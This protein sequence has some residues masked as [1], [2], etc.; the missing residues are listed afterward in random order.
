VRELPWGWEA[1]KIADVADVNPQ[2]DADLSSGVPVS[3]IPMASVEAETGIVDL[4]Q[5]KLFGE[6]RS[7]SYRHFREGDVL[8]AKITPCMENGK[9]AVA[10]GLTNGRGF[11][12][13]EF[14]VLRPCSGFNPDYLLY[15]LLQKT[16]RR[17]AARNMKGTAGQLRVPA[18]YLREYPIPVPPSEEQARIV[19]AIDEQFSRLDAG[20]A[21]LERVRQNLKRMR[22]AVLQAAV[23]GR[24]TAGSS[25]SNEA[26]TL[27][28]QLRLERSFAPMRTVLPAS[29]QR[30]PQFPKT[31]EV[32][33]LSDLA[34]S[35][36]YGTSE[37]THSEVNG[38]PVLRM[39]NIGWGDI[40]YSNLKYLEPE[41]LDSRL[42]LAPCDLLFNRTNSAE[43]VGKTAVFHGYTGKISFASYLIRVRPLP[44]ANMDWVSLVLNSS[45]GR[46]YMA[47]VRNQQV[48]QANVNGSKLAAAPIPLPP[49]SE[50]EQIVAESQR[51]F[52]LLDA[53]TASLTAFERD[54]NT[55]RSSILS[56]AF[57][58]QLVPQNPNDESARV[59]LERIAAEPAFSNGNK[60]R[61][62]PM[63]QAALL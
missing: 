63:R 45:L 49:E 27:V 12:S 52:S 4:S 34:A 2:F 15:Y 26:S 60:P 40:S 62:Q 5:T 38:V 46:E 51:L 28:T 8:F 55:L 7:K 23:T 31:W 43:L 6:L 11:G 59:L 41:R 42:L 17:D 37:K 58:G 44:S 47:A 22:A 16:L 25:S 24:L 21:A 19:A 39:G 30:A 33:S 53:L 36:D 29:F 14:H 3:F 20:V 10:R 50:Q 48:G 32:V 54:K 18:E 61:K 56:T 9:A 13:T 1:A 57:S 35:I